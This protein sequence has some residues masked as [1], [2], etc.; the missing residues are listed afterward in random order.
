MFCQPMVGGTTAGYIGYP[1]RV[2]GWRL[3]GLERS[4]AGFHK[5]I[6]G[7]HSDG[8]SLPRPGG[9]YHQGNNTQAR[10]SRVV[11][12]TFAHKRLQVLPT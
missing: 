7:N 3:S 9:L 5:K 1:L 10:V 11:Y 6:F 8:C 12:S 2:G 4:I